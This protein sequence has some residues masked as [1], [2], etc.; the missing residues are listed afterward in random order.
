MNKFA[1]ILMPISLIAFVL[2]AIPASAFSGSF[3]WGNIPK[4]TSGNPNS[5]GSPSFTLQDVPEGTVKLKFNL[6]DL[7][8]SYNHGGGTVAYSGKGNVPAGVES[9]QLFCAAHQWRQRKVGAVVLGG[10]G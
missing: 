9:N 10:C 6:A 8:V 1:V 3:D 4:C 7:N 2:T 5:A